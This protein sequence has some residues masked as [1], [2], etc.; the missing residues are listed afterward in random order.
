MHSWR[1]PDEST[2]RYLTFLAACGYT[3]SAVE[4]LAIPK[5]KPAKARAS[6]ARKTVAKAPSSPAQPTEA[7]TTDDST[8]QAAEADLSPAETA[9]DAEDAHVDQD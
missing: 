1:N 7:T 5:P 8:P 4:R 9:T 2:G 3:L 6:R